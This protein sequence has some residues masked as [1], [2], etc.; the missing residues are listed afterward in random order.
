MK[1]RRIIFLLCPLGL[2]LT[3]CSAPSA[4]GQVGPGG[5]LSFSGFDQS[6]G[7]PHQAALNAYPLTVMC[8]FKTTTSNDAGLV[9]KLALQKAKATIICVRWG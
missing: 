1:L 2:A 8:W 4:S 5:A 3:Y 6:V 7:V 9:D